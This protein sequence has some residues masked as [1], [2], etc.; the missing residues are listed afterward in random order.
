MRVGVEFVIEPRV[1]I[2]SVLEGRLYESR[3]VLSQAE[4]RA[5]QKKP[6][7]ENDDNGEEAGGEEE[8]GKD[9]NSEDIEALSEA[10]ELLHEAENATDRAEDML[11][12]YMESLNSRP[13]RREEIQERLRD[14][15]KLGKMMGKGIRT[16]TS[17][18]EIADELRDKLDAAAHFRG[19]KRRKRRK[20]TFGESES[21]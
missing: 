21:G 8:E 13:E 3:S 11:Q 6:V 20:I 7:G 15:D 17:M 12:R 16:A 10:I 4:R 19:R 2:Q 5:D 9:E 1:W 18:C 14:L